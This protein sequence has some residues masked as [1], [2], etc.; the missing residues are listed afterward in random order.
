MV[1][2]GWG[3]GW[4]TLHLSNFGDDRNV[5]RLDC[6]DGGTTQQIYEKALYRSFPVGSFYDMKVYVSKAAKSSLPHLT[7]S[8]FM[9]TFFWGSVAFCGSPQPS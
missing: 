4:E 9:A 3:W 2:R 6:G 1:A 7:I 5:L 8:S